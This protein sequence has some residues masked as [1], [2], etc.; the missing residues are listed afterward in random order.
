[1]IRSNGAIRALERDRDGRVA[2]AAPPGS[3]RRAVGEYHARKLRE[4][5]ERVREGFALMDSE[6]ID[7]F[8][9]GP[10][11]DGWDQPGSAGD[12]RP[13]ELRRQCAYTFCSLQDDLQSL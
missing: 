7:A 6:E 4:L 13:Y 1:L 10:L 11:G 8:E 12:G 9:L 2:R 5:L 3:A